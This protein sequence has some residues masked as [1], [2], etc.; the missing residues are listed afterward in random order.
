MSDPVHDFT[1]ICDRAQ[2]LKDPTDQA[3]ALGQA[4][5]AIPALQKYLKEWRQ[6]VVRQMRADGMND[7]EIGEKL[8]LTWARVSAIA[9]GV[10]TGGN[11]IRRRNRSANA[12]E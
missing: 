4:L 3:I 2:R 11:D 8:G 1:E 7:V 6:E 10:S 5:A 12:G 9:R